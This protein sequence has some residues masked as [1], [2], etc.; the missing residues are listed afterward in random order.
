M[1]LLVIGLFAFCCAAGGWIAAQRQQ[2]ERERLAVQTNLGLTAAQT[3]ER[4]TELESRL[5]SESS[6]SMSDIAQL[7]SFETR[8]RKEFPFL[9]GLEVRDRQG[10]LLRGGAVGYEQRERL[11]SGQLALLESALLTGRA[12]YRL[13]ER[14]SYKAAW[15][16]SLIVP[17]RRAET[18]SWFAQLDLGELVQTLWHTEKSRWPNGIDVSVSSWA[19]E[20]APNELALIE[21]SRNGLRL[22]ITAKI[23]SERQ[24]A[25]FAEQILT[26]LLAG[27]A[28]L[29]AGLWIRSLWMRQQSQRAYRELESKMQANAKIATLGEMS[30]AIAHE[31]NQPLGAIENYAHACE[32]LMLRSETPSPGVLEALRQI[33]CEAQ[34]GAEVIRSIRSLARRERGRVERVRLSELFD[35]LRPLLS[36]QAQRYGCEIQVE[37]DPSLTVVCEKTLL[38]Q[39]IVNLTNNG[40]EAMQDTPKA[41]RRLTLTAE[42]D[43]KEQAVS[44]VVSDNGAGI[45]QKYASSLFKPFFTTKTEGLGI[46]LNLCQTI[47]EQQGGAISWHNKSERG[48]VFTLRLPLAQTTETL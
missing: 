35:R 41:Q 18:E 16:I 28:G 2:E 20:A 14:S 5:Q 31:L 3:Q 1:V 36:I 17:A 6:A 22:A 24:T 27:L 40:F 39:V 4:L 46:G 8:L 33:R 23:N 32:R 21:L 43:P 26:S 44:V 12:E 47:A 30:T 19:P 10:R 34:R 38:E 11:A 25:I 9:L 42:F 7:D 13:D 48:A 29:M 15:P 45:S 37:T